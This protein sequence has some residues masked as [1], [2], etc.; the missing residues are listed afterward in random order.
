MWS[1]P[2]VAGCKD[3]KNPILHGPGH[4]LSRRFEDRTQ[5]IFLNE[6]KM[7]YAS[8]WIANYKRLIETIYRL[9]EINFRLLR[10]HYETLE[11]EG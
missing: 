6:V 7:K 10:Y 3:P 11:R 4:C 2:P 5:T 8:E 1:S 9:S